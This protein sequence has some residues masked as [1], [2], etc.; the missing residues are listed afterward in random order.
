MNLDFPTFPYMSRYEDL[1]WHV[2]KIENSW[3]IQSFLNA[4]TEWSS[5]LFFCTCTFYLNVEIVVNRMQEETTQI[6]RELY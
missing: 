3:T 1:V 6:G 5:D 2:T 4:E